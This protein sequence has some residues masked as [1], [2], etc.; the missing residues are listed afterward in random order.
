MEKTIEK[1]RPSLV[2]VD[3]ASNLDTVASETEVRSMLVRLV[4][5]LKTN[6]I[7]VL[8]TSLLGNVDVQE[9][10]V[11]ISSLMDTWILLRNIE[12]LGERRR[13]LYVLKARGIAHSSQVREFR[14]S[15]SGVELLDVFTGLQERAADAETV[16]M[17][18]S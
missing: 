9:Q 15:G 11:V 13:V 17:V 1:V 8:F 16:K 6:Q 14:L 10:Q 4:D 2:V 12:I 18:V 5:F 7:T 3:P